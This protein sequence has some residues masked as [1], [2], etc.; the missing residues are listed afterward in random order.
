MEM[1]RNLLNI[2]PEGVLIN[3]NG[4]GGTDKSTFSLRSAC[5]EEGPSVLGHKVWSVCLMQFSLCHQD[6]ATVYTSGH[7]LSVGKDK[8][9]GCCR[10]C[11]Q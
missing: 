9:V 3:V 11:G 8:T 6:G 1:A 4:I 2:K 7:L 10:L 5:S